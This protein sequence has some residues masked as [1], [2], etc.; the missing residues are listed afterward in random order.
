MIFINHDDLRS[1][2]CYEECLSQGLYVSDDINDLKYA[3]VIYLGQKGMNRKNNLF[4]NGETVLFDECILKNIHDNAVVI[5]LMYNEYLNELS[6]KY[7]F[8]YIALLCDENF[9]EENS[10]LT[11]EGLLSYLISHRLFPLYNSRILVLGYGHCGKAIVECL[12]G[13]NTYK[14]IYCRNNKDLLI[15]NAHI[16]HNIED[17]DFSI[18]DIIINTI[19]EVVVKKESID[20]MKRQVMIADIAIYPYGIDHHYALS[21]GLNSIIL[22]SIPNKY[23][24]KHAGNMIFNKIKGMIEC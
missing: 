3:D 13:F 24:Y 19:P 23:A 1:L 7:K 8:I 16:Y 14:Y 15:N 22:P 20:Q 9:I 2:E 11:A 5:T 18:F 6:N 21:R 12:K 4:V 17:I 10:I